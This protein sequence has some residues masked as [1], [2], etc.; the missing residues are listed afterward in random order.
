MGAFPTSSVSR[1]QAEDQT[2]GQL[3]QQN[4][5]VRAADAGAQDSDANVPCGGAR[6]G[7]SFGAV[8]KCLAAALVETEGEPRIEVEIFAASSVL[9][10]E[11]VVGDEQSRVVDTLRDR[12]G[13]SEEAWP[14]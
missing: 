4:R 7:G 13:Q 11:I 5:R 6:G 2:S 12:T 9:P 3:E 10:A 8:S 14:Q 1:G